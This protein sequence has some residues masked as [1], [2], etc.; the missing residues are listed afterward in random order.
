[1]K[2]RARIL[3]TALRTFLAIAA[4]FVAGCGVEPESI[5]KH[6]IEREGFQVFAQ[7][8]SGA[9]RATFSSA[10]SWI[11]L[12]SPVTGLPGRSRR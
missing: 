4:L 9:A 1:M 8:R 12:L 3:D 10:A 11:S 6:V 5:E 2:I 7:R